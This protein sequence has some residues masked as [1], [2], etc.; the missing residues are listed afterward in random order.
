MLRTSFGSN[1]AAKTL[2]E[3][4]LVDF[5]LNHPNNCTSLAKIC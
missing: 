5:Q 2:N 3:I 1:K 4:F